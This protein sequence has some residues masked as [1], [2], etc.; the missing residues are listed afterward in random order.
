MSVAVSLPAL[1]IVTQKP[2]FVRLQLV[3]LESILH[4]CLIR[5]WMNFGLLPS[6]GSAVKE[7]LE[8]FAENLLLRKFYH[9]GYVK[10]LKKNA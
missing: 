6:H 2:S 7:N 4:S 1:L 5:S 10:Y 8:L 3:W 9:L